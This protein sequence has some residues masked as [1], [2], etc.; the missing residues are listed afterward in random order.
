[1]YIPLSADGVEE[2]KAHPWFAD[3]D[4][5]KLVAREIVPEFTP[6][7]RRGTVDVSNFD[8][9]FT[10]EKAIDSLPPDTA[11]TKSEVDELAFDG[12]SNAGNV[13][14]I[15]TSDL[16]EG[17]IMEFTT[18]DEGKCNCHYFNTQPLL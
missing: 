9:E 16:P 12:F 17:S 13:Q 6:P 5:D 4:W 2:I 7:K 1:M 18:V 11:L 15:K 3:L 8:T 10:R 14:S